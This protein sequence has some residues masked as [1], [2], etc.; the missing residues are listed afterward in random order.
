MKKS[1]I[2]AL[3]LFLAVFA[4]WA[5]AYPCALSYQEQNQMFLYTESYLLN[6]ISYPGGICTYLSEWL[7]QFNYYPVVGAI[8]IALLL[9]SIYYITTC[10]I[11]KNT[12]S[13]QSSSALAIIP[14]LLLLDIL[15]DEQ[16]MLCYIVSLLVVLLASYLTQNLSNIFIGAATQAILY[17]TAGPLAYVYPLIKILN[18]GAGC[19]QKLALHLGIYGTILLIG[20]SLTYHF[21][22]PHYPLAVILQGLHYYR[23]I[24]FDHQQ[25]LILI[26]FPLIIPVL[27]AISSYY[28]DKKNCNYK[29]YSYALTIIIGIV[30]CTGF[31]H[32]CYN[33]EKYAQLEQDFLI[34]GEKWKKILDRAQQR[35]PHTAMSC[36]AVNLAL[37]MTHQLP[38]RQFEFYQCGIEGLI[39]PNQRDNIQMLPTMEAFYRLGLINLANWYAFEAQQAI[40]N[41]QQSARLTQRLAECNLILG[42]HEVAAKYISLLKQTQFYSQWALKAEQLLGRDEL[43]ARH[44]EYGKLRTYLLKDEV[45]CLFP[46]QEVEKIIGRSLLCNPENDLAKAYYLSAL[47]LKGLREQFVGLLVP[48][49]QQ[50]ANPFPEGFKEYYKR[51]STKHLDDN[52]VPN[53]TTSATYFS[54][55]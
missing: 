29:S 26:V 16:V 41:L 33:A 44:S 45:D 18:L 24:I 2:I 3:L 23:A 22:A 12:K 53:A 6:R 49:Q 34:R 20:V 42:R 55:S 19:R 27:A 52:S 5:F 51:M 43:V 13:S 35:Q 28:S 30:M 48:D 36:T 4:H 25:P 50:L 21:I 17:F 54:P 38:E 40:P 39:L 14:A 31:H 8:I 11:Q 37:A 47:L 7:T 46:P 9:T 15:G 1:F 10:L 32:Y